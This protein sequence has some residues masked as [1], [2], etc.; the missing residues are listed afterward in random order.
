MNGVWTF[1]SDGASWSGPDGIWARL[2]EHLQYSVIALVVAALIALPLGALI[3]HTGKG[4]TV[5]VGVA[6]LLRALPS[7]GL[8][9]LLVLWGLTIVQDNPDIPARW[10]LYLPSIL[11]L[12]ILGIPPILTNTYAGIGAVDPAVRDAAKGLGMTGGQVL[13]RVELPVAAPLIYAGIRSAFLQIVA[14]ATILALVVTLGGLGRFILDGPKATENPY[15]IMAG[16]A[17]LVALLA[18]VG[19]RVIAAVGYAATSP[20][21]RLA[22]PGGRRRGFGR[23]AGGKKTSAPDSSPLRAAAPEQTLDDQQLEETK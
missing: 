6:N 5:A 14:T 20:G 2:G 18:I 17:V 1:L 22:G 3:G 8:L 21:L 12:V 15:G 7:L 4:A 9:T 19:D 13:R 23:F 11:V 10:G 16:G